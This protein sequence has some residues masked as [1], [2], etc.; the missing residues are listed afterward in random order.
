MTGHE[1]IT[2]DLTTYAVHPTNNDIAS[3][4]GD[5]SQASEKNLTELLAA[6]H[7]DT[8]WVA[9]GFDYV[10]AAGLVATFN[11]GEA[12]IDGHRVIC[13][14]TFSFTLEA[15]STNH[16]WISWEETADLATNLTVYNATS[17]TP[18]STPYIKIATVTTDGSGVTA[19]TDERV[20]D[21]PLDQASIATTKGDILVRTAAALTR[22][23]VGSNNQVLTADSAEASGIKWADPA[24]Y[25]EPTA[26]A[27]GAQSGAVSGWAT[28]TVTYTGQSDFGTWST[29][30]NGGL[31]MSPDGTKLYL[32]QYSNCR[33]YEFDLST[34]YDVT[35]RSYVQVQNFSNSVSNASFHVGPTGYKMYHINSFGQIAEHTLS[36]AWDVSSYSSTSLTS[37]P[38]GGDLVY[39]YDWGAMGFADSGN[40]LYLWGRNSSSYFIAK[41]YSMSTPYDLS[42]LSYTGQFVYAS[43]PG[44]LYGGVVHS[45][46]T[47]MRAFGGSWSYFRE[48]TLTTPYDITTASSVIVIYDSYTP[49][50]MNH[51]DMHPYRS[52]DN[53]VNCW[54]LHG[55]RYIS[56]YNSAALSAANTTL[57]LSTAGVFQIQI[58][59]EGC[60]LTFSNS[61]ACQAFR[62]EITNG[63][64]GTITWPASVEWASGTAPTLTT[65]GTDVLEFFTRDS[66]TTW[67]GRV[68]VLNAS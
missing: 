15:S 64:T 8:A 65:T 46:G 38:A 57:D 47:K 6:L 2:G 28:S 44:A 35:S 13:T 20:T 59:S 11:G 43:G 33:T 29:S 51:I 12:I 23:G 50:S 37:I 24:F 19:N 1:S 63:N 5:G 54:Y 14:G 31:G 26:S 7:N 42:T 30:L 52:T 21:H 40:E 48:W 41:Q 53:G 39:D 49:G 22:L 27:L 10:S 58:Q 55:D 34:P 56:I 67:I 61:D 68:L 4:A 3:T 45:S 66:G 60:N 18:P 17:D 25:I 9:S 32:A 62:L 36:T 16:V